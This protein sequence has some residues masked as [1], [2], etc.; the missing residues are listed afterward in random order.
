MDNKDNKLFIVLWAVVG[1][2]L[3]ALALLVPITILLL[4]LKSMTVKKEESN[5]NL[6][7]TPEVDSENPG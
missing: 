5:E 2:A 4:K 1:D 6:E 7:A 3:L